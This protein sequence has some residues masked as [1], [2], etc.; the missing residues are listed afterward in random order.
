MS[1]LKETGPPESPDMFAQ[2]TLN[3]EIYA[4]MENYAFID[5]PL[6]LQE[7]IR[8]AYDGDDADQRMER[9][10]LGYN[11]LR[12]LK[13]STSAASAYLSTE[14]NK[15]SATLA[16]RRR[17]QLRLVVSNI[18]MAVL[19]GGITAGATVALERLLA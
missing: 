16:S 13:P 15:L 7:M 5:L 9:C 8:A 1:N 19:L 4:E 18:L 11:R 6:D 2:R 10:R 17:A 12:F 3:W 14:M